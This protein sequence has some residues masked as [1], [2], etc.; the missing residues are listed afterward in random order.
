MFSAGLITEDAWDVVTL[1]NVEQALSR[2]TSNAS[3]DAIGRNYVDPDALPF[4]F[5]SLTFA[6][7]PLFSPRFSGRDHV[8]FQKQ[9]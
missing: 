3:G 5:I 2:E 1:D 4:R 7:R 9:A 6:L 8:R